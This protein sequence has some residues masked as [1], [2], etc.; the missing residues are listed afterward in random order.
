[1]LEILINSQYFLNLP[2]NIEIN[3]IEENPLFLT[4]RIPA[5][6][7][8][9]F[10]VPATITNLKA[11]GF[12]GRVTSNSVKKKV[13]AEIR[14]TGIVLTRGEILLL[15]ANDVLKLQ[16][17]G[18]REPEEITA[19]LNEINYGE[20]SYGSFPYHAEDLDYQDALLEDYIRSMKAMAF[21]G[22]DYVIAPVK[23]EGTDWTG[24]EYSNG[25]KNSVRQYINYLNP[26]R[27]DF[28]IEN[29]H[30]A[31]TPILPYIYVHK[32]IE[33][34]FGKYLESNPFASG[35]LAKLVLISMNHPN[36]AF[37]NQYSWYWDYINF[38]DVKIDVMFP[39]VDSYQ[40]TN[41]LI[42][43]HWQFNNFCQAYSFRE[44]LK[45]LL[46][47]FCMTAYPGITYRIE[48]SDIVMSRTKQIDW[49]DKLADRLDISYEEGQAYYFGYKNV[50]SSDE[51]ILKKYQ[52]VSEIFNAAI[53]QTSEE[54][55]IYRNSD[56]AQYKISRT[57]RGLTSE[58]WLK[59]EIDHS[60]LAT[61]EPASDK[62][63]F[64]II[65]DLRPADMTIEHY[66]WQDKGVKGDLVQRKHW[67]VPVVNKEKLDQPP[68]LM[69]FVGRTDTFQDEG[70]Y[71]QLLAHHTDQ[72]G[73]KR[74]NTSLHPDGPG[75]LIEKYHSK[76]K[77]WVE[78][79]KM[80]AKGSFKLS[81][82]EL[83][84]LDIRDKV[85]LQGK[86]FY[87]QKLNFTLCS[88]SIGLVDV[89]LVES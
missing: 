52:T 73:I 3:F 44:L 34:A 56:D 62:D 50:K 80:K 48:Y 88:S 15:E 24:S 5:P 53:T 2:A 19:N 70:S 18:S 40:S 41:E 78:K 71:P 72:F 82:L 89:D 39:L 84:K 83:K 37:D 81:I 30:K 31:H 14:H 13:H 76:M 66:W 38:E 74:L 57:L 6:Y 25:M 7:T 61:A 58:P 64:E 69:F 16:F 35:D 86:L 4:D 9:S 32:I 8:L 11:F 67:F 45:N 87:I 63:K 1:M 75:G 46:K 68:Y 33:V 85:F 77:A 29:I 60:P 23:I 49:S 20:R 59:C 54:G 42:P 28:F 47:I 27:G 22:S 10:E 79:D 43:I 12:A 65:S 21:S 26:V 17:K 36:Y 51:K 55:T